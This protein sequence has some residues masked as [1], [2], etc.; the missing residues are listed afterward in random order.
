[1]DACVT[2]LVK[3]HASTI[4]AEC[5]KLIAANQV[6]SKEKHSVEYEPESIISSPYFD[7]LDSIHVDRIVSLTSLSFVLP[8]GRLERN[9]G[10]DGFLVYKENLHHFVEYPY[11]VLVWYYEVKVESSLIDW[12][13]W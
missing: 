8:W 10:K 2:V 6:E 4:V 7:P 13:K 11:L 1:M 3:D 5:P 12:E 9:V